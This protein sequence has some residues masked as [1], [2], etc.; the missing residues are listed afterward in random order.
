M[1]TDSDLIVSVSGVRG[2]VGG[3]LTPHVVLAFASAFGK[4]LDGG[5]VVVSRDGRPSGNMLGHAILAGLS[6]AG[7]EVHDLAVA[8]T[9]TVGLAVR[10]LNAAG[11]IQITASHNPAQW[12]GLKLFGAD[13]RVLSATVGREVAEM[14]AEG[15]G[16]FVSWDALQPV[17]VYHK[18]DDDHRDRILQLIDVTR[19]RAAQLRAFVDANGGAGGGSPSASCRQARASGRSR[20][21]TPATPTVSFCTNRS[22]PR[23][24]CAASAHWSPSSTPT[25]ASRSI[26][27]PTASPCSTRR[28]A[29]SARN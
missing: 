27:T 23:R 16:R 20:T 21:A 22:R 9:P 13:G 3:S 5:R 11:G 25:S 18:A 26:P 12:N 24:T 8:A 4:Y 19:I 6:A 10:T 29:T 1:T 14:F 7:C 28:A 2:V 15:E 17:Q